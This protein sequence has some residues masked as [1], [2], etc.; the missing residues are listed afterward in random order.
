MGGWG[1]SRQ[2]YMD[3]LC[4]F[5]VFV[6]IGPLKGFPIGLLAM[7]LRCKHMGK[8]PQ[9]FEKLTFQ[10]CVDLV[11]ISFPHPVGVF[12]T[13]LEPPKCHIGKQMC[14]QKQE[15]LIC[16]LLAL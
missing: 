6:P 3:I 7:P 2:G 15:S 14:L 16:S 12:C 8:V 10:K 4:F 5:V 13:L 9:I 11:G 1:Y